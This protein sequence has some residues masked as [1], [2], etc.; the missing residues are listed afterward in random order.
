MIDDAFQEFK[1]TFDNALAQ[2]NTVD[3]EAAAL[4]RPL[5]NELAEARFQFRFPDADTTSQLAQAATLLQHLPDSSTTL[6]KVA[7][8]LE[9]LPAATEALTGA[10]KQAQQFM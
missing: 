10:L 4:L 8:D 5:I 3:R 7:K 9:G 1:A 2:L 6:A